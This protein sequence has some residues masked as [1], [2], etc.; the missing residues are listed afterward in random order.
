MNACTRDAQLEE[1]RKDARALMDERASLLA[2]EERVL[3]MVDVA[4]GT[5]RAEKRAFETRTR[6]LREE[7]AS[8]RATLARER[9]A[10]ASGESGSRERESADARA[11]GALRRRGEELEREVETLTTKN[12]ELHKE[13]L[14]A[15]ANGNKVDWLEG[16]ATQTRE[17]LEASEATMKRLKADLEFEKSSVTKYESKAIA[18]EKEKSG[19]EKALAARDGKIERLEDQLQAKEEKLATMASELRASGALAPREA[20]LAKSE[21]S[22][23][24]REARARERERRRSRRRSPS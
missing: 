24:A 21:A 17:R 9:E 7:L 11:I 5:Y 16:E 12:R 18:L 8:V 13:A 20:A 2:R 14:L 1:A 22:V 6:E 23:E 10:R 19:L 15:K 3:R 4:D